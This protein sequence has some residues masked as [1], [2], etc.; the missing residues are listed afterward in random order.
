VLYTQGKVVK[1]RAL[2]RRPDGGRWNSEALEEVKVSPYALYRRPDAEVVFR[3]DPSA[4]RQE[5]AER[6]DI[7]VRDINL[8]Q[9]DFTEHGMTQNGCSRCNWAIRHGWEHGSS[10][11]HSAD[12]R[13]RMREAIRAS[14]PAGKARVEAW[15][16]RKRKAEAANIP[17]VP[18]E[19]EKQE[20]DREGEDDPH[21][22]EEFIDGEIED[23]FDEKAEEG[24]DVGDLD[25]GGSTP[26]A[27]DGAESQGEQPQSPYAPTSPAESKRG[28][29]MDEDVGR[30][31]SQHNKCRAWSPARSRVCGSPARSP[32]RSRVCGSPAR[33]RLPA[34]R[35]QA[36][37]GPS[38]SGRS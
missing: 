3:N 36:S 37:N 8:R 29:D 20:G 38:A 10:L 34:K 7:V 16:E 32:A 13:H 5:A 1:T 31:E 21:K 14:G 35:L 15:E 22:F 27:Q 26:R 17:A 23:M 6:K 2:Q 9:E 25:L 28:V 24:P 12:C 4:R 11:S 19:G 33:R 18:A 30:I